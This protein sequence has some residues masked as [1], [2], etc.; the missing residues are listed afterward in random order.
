ML[1]LL[2]V[3]MCGTVIDGSNNALQMRICR[4]SL[5]SGAQRMSKH[6]SYSVTLRARGFDTEA[7]FVHVGLLLIQSPDR[8]PSIPRKAVY[9]HKLYI[10]PSF[11]ASP[12][13]ETVIRLTVSLKR[14]FMVVGERAVASSS[15]TSS[16][17]ISPQA[18]VPIE[19]EH[20]ADAHLLFRVTKRVQIRILE[21]KVCDE[22]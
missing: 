1:E 16:G 13:N 9:C 20:G 8:L 21:M 11:R 4:Y 6:S 5:A 7:A 14:G 10:G 12:R 2:C 18:T 3:T 17:E 15:E 22:I 19:T